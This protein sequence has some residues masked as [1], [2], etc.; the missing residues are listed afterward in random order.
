[1]RFAIDVLFL[2]RRGRVLS[3]RENLPPWRIAG[4][5]RG[6]EAVLELPA[7][8]IRRLGLPTGCDSALASE[9]APAALDERSRSRSWRGTDTAQ[10]LVEFALVLPLLLLLIV[11]A[12]EFGRGYQSWLTLSNA[13]AVGARTASVGEPAGVVATAVRNA[14]PTLN[15]ST[16]VVQVDNAQG[17]TGTPVTVRVSYGLALIT[18]VVAGLVPNGTIDLSVTAVQRLE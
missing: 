8:A 15:P 11:G 18:P 5:V 9:T 7:G 4:P 10:S 17:D 14:A 2:D 13:A 12:I 6:A 1:M 3:V 16:L